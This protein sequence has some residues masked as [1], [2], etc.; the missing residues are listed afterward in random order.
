MG[1]ARGDRYALSYQYGGMD[2]LWNIYQPRSNGGQICAQAYAVNG[3]PNLPY[4]N[5]MNISNREVSAQDVLFDSGKENFASGDRSTWASTGSRAHMRKPFLRVWT[6]I[7]ATDR[8]GKNINSYYVNPKGERSA[9]NIY[10]ENKYWLNTMAPDQYSRGGYNTGWYS[11]FINY[12]V[13][14][15]Y[16]TNGGGKGT[17]YYPVVTDILPPGI[18]PLALDGA[19]SEDNEKNASLTLDWTLYGASYSGN[20]REELHV[21]NGEDGS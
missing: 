3:S 8:S 16:S 13:R 2:W 11:A 9:L 4:I 20:T 12:A 18:V 7:G 21:L 19:F 6:T 15:K 10:V 1:K 5:G 17:L 14:H